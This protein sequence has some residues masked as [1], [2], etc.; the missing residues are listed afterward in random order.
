MLNA[1]NRKKALDNSFVVTMICFF[2]IT[3]LFY[4]LIIGLKPGTVD[5]LSVSEIEQADLSEEYVLLSSQLADWYPGQLYE[6]GNFPT[7]F[8]TSTESE[9]KYGTYR[10]QLN[11]PKD[12]TYG[13]TGFTSDYS[14]KVY[15]NGELLSEVGQVCEDIAQFT[16]KTDSYSIFFT[17]ETDTSEIVIQ[18]AY[19]NHAYGHL[20]DIYLAEQQVIVERNRAEVLS[21]GLILGTLLSFAMFFFGMFISYTE[22]ISFLWFSITCFSAVLHHS[23]YYSKD[24]MV[25]LPDLSWYILH[26]VEYISRIC[27]Y[28]FL[29]THVMSVI[30]IKM[31]RW[32][33]LF[34]YGS[35]GAISLFYI[36]TPSTFYTKY[37]F[38]IGLYITVILV[39]LSIYILYK[40]YRCKVF[41]YKENIIVSLSVVCVLISWL[42]EALTY[43]GLSWY[44]QPYL[45]ILVVFFNAIALTIQFSRT[46]RELIL[47]Q[48]RER[49]IARNADQLERTNN[50]K[51]D[52]FHKMAHEIKT[53]LAIMSG[54][55]QLTNKQ[56]END[57]VTAET[58]LNLRVIS[59]EAKRLSE[60]VMNLM[61]MPT[62]PISDEEFNEISVAEYLHYASA[63]CKGILEKRGNSL[64]IKGN[65]EQH[66]IGNMEMLVQMMINLAIN[67]NKHMKNGKFTIEAKEALDGN[68]MELFVSDTGTGVSKENEENIFKKGFTTDG[69]KGL[70]LSICKEIAE[71][72][73]GDIILMNDNKQ[74]AVF[75]ISIPI[76]KSKE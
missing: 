11:I 61:E 53:P 25:F 66:I 41:V 4:M 12:K 24:I 26:K 56:I 39:M 68:N 60:L 22:R 62:T 50:M 7:T 28:F 74:G 71:L 17:P 75:K 58:T 57:E 69:T 43:Q 2:V 34:N 16:P 30:K 6:P 3:S 67:S 64:N 21:N 63:V 13:I 54:Y 47:S 9:A 8:D 27:F 5:I 14:Q 23:I 49:E 70:G 76:F 31:S 40:G 44:V 36:F 1:G 32:M 38:F 15:V 20:K 18:L 19:H 65:T 45:T 46:E 37:V 72:H 35:F 29:F 52:F 33:K 48:T 51:T 59:S 55:A 42:V 10:I 73:K